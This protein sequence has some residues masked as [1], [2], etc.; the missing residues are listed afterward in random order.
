MN[1][2]KCASWQTVVVIQRI[3]KL[4]EQRK[5]EEIISSNCLP[6]HKRARSFMNKYEAP[7]L[8]LLTMLSRYRRMSES[9]QHDEQWSSFHDRWCFPCD[10]QCPSF[11]AEGLINTLSS[12]DHFSIYIHIIRI[13]MKMEVVYSFESLVSFFDATQWQYPEDHQVNGGHPG[14]FIRHSK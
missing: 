6:H 2:W 7:R 14:V 5:N 3:P 8:H 1:E 13:I 4:R 9:V 10:E 12:P 11:H